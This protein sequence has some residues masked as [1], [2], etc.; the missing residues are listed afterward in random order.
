MTGA[1]QVQSVFG[2][3][4]AVVK[5]IRSTGQVDRVRGALDREQWWPSAKAAIGLVSMIVRRERDEPASGVSN[6]L[7]LALGG[8]GDL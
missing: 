1:E 3:W 7:G 5:R 8:I 2:G 4:S 6:R